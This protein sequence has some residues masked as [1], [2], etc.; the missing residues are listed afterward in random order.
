MEVQPVEAVQINI[1]QSNT[2]RLKP[3]T[4]R[5][6][7]LSK[8]PGDE[9]LPLLIILLKVPPRSQ[10]MPTWPVNEKVLYLDHKET[11]SPVTF[12]KI[13]SPN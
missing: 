8:C 12:G 9:W 4:F 2:K 3:A 7:T 5:Q 1:Y 11:L 10:I 6:Y 13:A